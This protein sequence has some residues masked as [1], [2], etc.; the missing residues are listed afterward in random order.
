MSDF[1]VNNL[2]N[3]Y[4]SEE[5]DNIFDKIQFKFENPEKINFLDNDFP[6]SP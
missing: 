3:D 2:D 4:K 6:S 5:S 1:E